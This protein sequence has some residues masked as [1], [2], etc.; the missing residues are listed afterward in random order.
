VTEKSPIARNDGHHDKAISFGRFNMY[1]AFPRHGRA[2]SDYLSL[3]IQ[4]RSFS[5]SSR[6]VAATHVEIQI[7]R[8]WLAGFGPESIPKQICDLSFSRSSG[9]GG[10]NVNK[11]VDSQ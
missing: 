9:P 2:I 4:G 3:D 11:Y 6:G 5:K 8:D 7:A 1:R 10:Q